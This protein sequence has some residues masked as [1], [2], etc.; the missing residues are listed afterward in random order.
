MSNIEEK[1]IKSHP[2]SFQT[3]IQIDMIDINNENVLR[4]QS[5]TYMIKY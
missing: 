3:M 2:S 1:M 5:Y 4:F